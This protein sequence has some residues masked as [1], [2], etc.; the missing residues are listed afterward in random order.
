MTTPL[1][2]DLGFVLGQALAK[3]W[4]DP[5]RHRMSTMVTALLSADT[6][7]VGGA[8]WGQTAAERVVR[9]NRF[10]HCELDTRVAIIDVALPSCARAPTCP[11]GS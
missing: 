2:V 4:P 8:E 3:D 5:T 6:E 11:S 9:R 10:P 7:V 1:V